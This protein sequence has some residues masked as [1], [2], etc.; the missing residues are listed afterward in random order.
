VL[1]RHGLRLDFT[2]DG[3]RVP[4]DIAAADVTRLVCRAACRSPLQ[5]GGEDVDMA[6]RFGR[7]AVATA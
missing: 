5:K 1:I 4:E 2:T 6:E 7:V 3:Q